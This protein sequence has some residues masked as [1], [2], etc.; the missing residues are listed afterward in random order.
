[1]MSGDDEDC[2]VMIWKVVVRVPDE[3]QSEPAKIGDHQKT[4]PSSMTGIVKVYLRHLAFWGA[5]LPTANL[6]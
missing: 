4:N 6:R 1:M 3:E 5:S 2:D